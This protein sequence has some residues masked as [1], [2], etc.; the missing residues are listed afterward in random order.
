MNP[1]VKQAHSYVGHRFKVSVKRVSYTIDY[2]K[3]YIPIEE[4]C[5]AEIYK[6]NELVG[7]VIRSQIKEVRGVDL[8]MIEMDN[9]RGAYFFADKELPLEEQITDAINNIIFII[10]NNDKYF[11]TIPV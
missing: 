7:R 1:K 3:H 10:G 6:G 8:R 4:T 9:D 2:S 11:E 5:Y